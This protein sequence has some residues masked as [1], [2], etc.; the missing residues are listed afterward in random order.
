MDLAASG[1]VDPATGLGGVADFDGSLNSNGSQ[2]KATGVLTCNKLKLSPKGSPA[3]KPVTVKYAVNADLD[4]QSG[5]I[6]QGD[7]SIGK[8]LAHL[9]GGFQTQGEAQLLNLKLSAPNMP[10]DELE[11]MLPALGVVLP[12]GSQLQGGTL[13]AELAITGPVDKPVITGPVRLA[14]TK[15]AGFDLGSKLG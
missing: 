12:S 10:V 4:K 6:T 3:S 11:A 7:V 2:A 5:V 14:N 15:L 1:F 8:A 9:A 13:S